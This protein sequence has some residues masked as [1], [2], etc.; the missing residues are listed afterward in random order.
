MHEPRYIEVVFPFA[1]KRILG[2][3]AFSRSSILT[4]FG[5]VVPDCI[6]I[7]IDTALY[8]WFWFSKRCLQSKGKRRCNAN[9]VASLEENGFLTKSRKLERSVKVA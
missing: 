2:I 3:N 6:K 8:S 1:L 4:T 9:I 5:Q 7:I